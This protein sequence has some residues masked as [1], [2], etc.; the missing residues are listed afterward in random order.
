M[1]SKGKSKSKL[2]VQ[3]LAGGI[4]HERD[5]SL[6]SGRRVAD[7]LLEAG[8]EVIIREPDDKL[9]S[10][11]KKDKPDVIW[12]CLH[13][14]S[15]EDGALRDIL[16][17]AGV[18][19]VGATASGARLAWD[20]SIAKVIVAQAGIQTPASITLPKDTFRELDAD[21]VLKA[22]T[23][24]ISFPLVVKPARSGSAQGVSVVKKADELSRAMVD[25]YVY[26]D[27]AI[28]EKYIEGTELAISV[29]D[30]GSGPIALPAVE[31]EPVSGRFGYQERY[32]AGETNYYVPARV[33]KAIGERAAKLATDSHVAL[34]LRHISRVDAIVD[35]K[36]VVWFLEAN[37]CPGMTETSLLPQAITAEGSTL[38]S[39]YLSLAEAAVRTR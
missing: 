8:A 9:F 25:A 1:I 15:G 21:G 11:I 26:C 32:T 28:I 6:K 34:G 2:K 33:S 36:G 23:Q 17:L 10:N 24:T 31:V 16:S 14:A 39:V 4:S 22:V 19:F 37:V 30:L 38:S 12:P 27:V 7:A 29:I 3:I 35:K 18:P 20:K 5:I 13:G